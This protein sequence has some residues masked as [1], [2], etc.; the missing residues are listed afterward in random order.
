MGLSGGE[1]ISTTSLVVLTQYRIVTD[2]WTDRQTNGIN[3]ASA[4]INLCG[5]ATSMTELQSIKDLN[6]S[7]AVDNHHALSHISIKPLTPTH[8]SHGYRYSYKPSCA[9]PG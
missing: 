4:F 7:L 9:R 1:R 6:A 3:I 2:G 8:C 5:R